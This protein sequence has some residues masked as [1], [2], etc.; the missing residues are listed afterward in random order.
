MKKILYSEQAIVRVWRNIKKLGKVPTSHFGHAAVTV[1]GNSV[2]TTPGRKPHLQNISFWPDEGA[3]FGNAYKMIPGSFGDSAKQDKLSEMNLLTCVRLEVGY[4]QKNGMAYP[5][6]WDTLLT[7]RNK[8]PLPSPRT[9]QKKAY[10][11]TGPRERI[12]GELYLNDGTPVDVPMYYQSPESN[13][14]LP[15]LN[16]RGGKFGLNLCRMANWWID[17]QKTN[18]QYCALSPR[19]NCV[20]VALMGLQEGGADSIV[21]PPTFRTYAEPVQ[22]ESYAKELETRFLQL[23]GMVYMLD[24]GIRSDHLALRPPH[25]FELKDGL[26]RLDAWKRESALGLMYQRSTL[27][28]EI[29]RNMATFERLT[30]KDNFVERYQAFMNIFLAVLRHRQEKS[31][32]KRAEAVAQLGKQMLAVIHAHG[33][34]D[35]FVPRFHL[36]L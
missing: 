6:E 21:K 14:Y 11:S 25:A 27:I 18:P 36:D 2:R 33:F 5:P 31:D 29:D 9:G 7:E 32:S 35:L 26:W 16:A 13:V 34:Y 19:N 20:G 30:W 28:C 8:A 12:Y 23:D 1:S 17:F 4:R 10:E 15:G 24:A 3:T 22:L